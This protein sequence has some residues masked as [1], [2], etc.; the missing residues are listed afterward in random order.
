MT[1]FMSKTKISTLV[2]NNM[3]IVQKGGASITA[4]KHKELQFI[5]INFY[6]IK[7]GDKPQN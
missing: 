6:E 4:L 5:N 7:K 1:S 2:S 3:R